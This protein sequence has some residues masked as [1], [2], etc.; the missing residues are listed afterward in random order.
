MSK[1]QSDSIGGIA[2]LAAAGIAASQTPAAGGV[3]NL[4]IDGSLASGGIATCDVARRIEISSA[5]D[6]SARTFT[7][8][9]T[10][11][12]GATI[13]E[14]LTGPN[15]SVISVLDYKTVTAI[16]VDANTAGAVASSTVDQVSGDWI[17]VDPSRNPFNVTV[18]CEV[19]SDST[20]NYTV[21]YT[22]VGDDENVDTSATKVVYSHDDTDLV[23]ATT[24]Q[25]GN[26]AYP[27]THTRVHLNSGVSS[28]TGVT[29]KVIQAG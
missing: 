25:V 2:A 16:T 13:S 3:Q 22:I 15:T 9:G 21:Q 28:G 12:N 17:K 6:E 1:L 19:A 10:D 8:T 26:F 5:G 7:L 29:L 23:A 20:L 11:R 27:C 24:T 4:T 18:A 14:T